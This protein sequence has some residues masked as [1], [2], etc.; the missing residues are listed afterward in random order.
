MKLRNLGNS[1]LQVSAVGLGTWAMGNDFFGHVE[2]RQSIDAIQAALDNGVN[3]VDTAPAYGSGHSEEVVGKAI[4]GR[5][6]GVIIATKVGTYRRGKD[7]VRDLKPASVRKQLEDSLRR[8]NVDVID[9][10]QI[11]WPDPGTPLEESLGELAKLKEEGKYRYLGVSNFSIEQMETVR[12]NMDLTSLQPHF[13]LLERR[14]ES[15]ILPF[16]RKNAIG[17]LGYGTLAGGI[18]TGKFREIPTLPE[19]DTRDQ[20]YNFFREPVWTG[21][22]QLIDLLRGI[23]EKRGVPVAH[24]ATAWAFQQE[25]MTCTLVG[26][27]NREQAKSNAAAGDLEL[28]TDELSQI[29]QG[30]DNFAASH[31]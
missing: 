10:Y 31:R 2:D 3:L 15:D 30:V 19:G 23:A 20:F 1:D 6:E 18:L 28:S 17:V 27:K 7:F 11:H 16:C 22:Q 14:I 25:G 21:V 13:S 12:R 5:R 29:R 24:V 8:L 4:V 9:L 26:A